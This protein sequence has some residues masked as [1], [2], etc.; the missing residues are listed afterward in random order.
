VAGKA[1]AGPAGS[2]SVIGNADSDYLGFG[3]GIGFGEGFSGSFTVGVQSN[4]LIS[5]RSLESLCDIDIL[6]YSLAFTGK[7]TWQIYTNFYCY[8]Y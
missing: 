1:G 5:N 7:I 4:I 2:I 3:V 8:S 6:M